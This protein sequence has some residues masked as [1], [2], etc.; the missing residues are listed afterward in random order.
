VGRL[1]A[2]AARGATVAVPVLCLLCLF[3]PLPASAAPPG[4]FD[5]AATAAGLAVRSTQQ[6]AASVVTAGLVDATAGYATSAL[7]S[8]GAAESLAAAAY[9]GNL[10]DN[11]PALLCAAFLPCPVPPPRDPLV[12]EASYPTR[13][14]AE[15]PAGGSAPAGTARAHAAAHDTSA[16]AAGAATSTAGP[17]PVQ[18]AAQSVQTHGWV[19]GSG[20]HARS[21]SVVHGVRVGPLSISVLDSTVAVDVTSDGT[22]RDRPA[23]TLAGVTFAGQAASVDEDGVHVA[24]RDQAL[25]DRSLAQQ[26]LSVRLIGT[27]RQD[28]PGAGRSTAGGLLVS[29]SVPVQGVPQTVPGLP[30]AD[31]TYVGTVTVG[32]AGAV[33]AASTPPAFVLPTLPPPPAGSAAALFPALPALPPTGPA[34]Q[35]T[36]GLAAVPA[37][38][39][40]PELPPTRPAGLQLPDLSTLA[41]LLAIVTLALLAFWRAATYLS[42]RTR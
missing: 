23:V 39:A 13:P 29:F 8:Y 4:V 37:P 17:V 41:L 16:T 2:W 32:G 25:P 6:P 33:V 1:P 27:G 9:P 21:H 5:V 38:A 35:P 12:A 18:V 31:R 42:W 24:G 26:G 28:A 10:V 3:C 11:G 34:G 40:A 36:P 14:A 30:S 19:D 22:V 7:S 15:A 20:A